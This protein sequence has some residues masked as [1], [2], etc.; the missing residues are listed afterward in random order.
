MIGIWGQTLF[1][2]IMSLNLFQVHSLLFTFI[3][4]H[5]KYFVLCTN[6]DLLFFS[7]FLIFC[8][9]PI[10]MEV[11]WLIVHLL[12]YFFISLHTLDIYSICSNSDSFC[13]WKA[14]FAHIYWVSYFLASSIQTNMVFTF[15]YG[16]I[17][18][19]FCIPSPG[20][21]ISQDTIWKQP[22]QASR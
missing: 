18:D 16:S 4:N 9:E 17:N 8:L 11:L 13:N 2:C 7:Y 10:Y 6:G 20:E 15:V 19:Y 3:C 14:V 21:H 5:S 1:D 12:I 22:H